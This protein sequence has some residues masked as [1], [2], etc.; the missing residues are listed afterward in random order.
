MQE[1]GR[2]IGIVAVVLW[3]IFVGLL[4]YLV[5][6]LSWLCV[7][8]VVGGCFMWFLVLRRSHNRARRKGQMPESETK[9]RIV[10]LVA[11]WKECERREMDALRVYE[12]LQ[13]STKSVRAKLDAVCDHKEWVNLGDGLFDRRLRCTECSLIK[14]H[15]WIC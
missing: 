2:F 3:L 11:E 5:V 6:A 12:A 9:K 13:K 8:I 7:T 4:V 10:V 15:I 1:R 14:G